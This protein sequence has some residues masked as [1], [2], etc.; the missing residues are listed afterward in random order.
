MFIPL[1]FWFC[2]NNEYYDSTYSYG[3]KE[4]GT[5]LPNDFGLYNMNGNLQEWTHDS[6]G[7]GLGTMSVI[8]PVLETEF[9][10]VFRGGSWAWPPYVFRSA[11]RG[12]N[13]PY[14]SA[15]D[16]GFRVGRTAP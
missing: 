4:V 8:D 13:T 6:Y 2:G 1:K 14:H 3:S 16:I 5:L 11:R 7:G 10:H 9:R 12:Y 15:S